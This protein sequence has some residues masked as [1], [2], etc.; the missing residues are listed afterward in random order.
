M[1]SHWLG[2]PCID[3]Y[4]RS[5]IIGDFIL[6]FRSNFS[7]VCIKGVFELCPKKFIPELYFDFIYNKFYSKLTMKS[8]LVFR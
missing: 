7:C 6:R 3:I 5:A 4:V 2:A 1:Y 8:S